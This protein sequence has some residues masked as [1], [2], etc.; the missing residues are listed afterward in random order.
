M[1]IAASMFATL[2]SACGFLSTLDRAH[3]ADAR[4]EALEQI[5]KTTIAICDVVRAEGSTNSLRAQG[6]IDGEVKGLLRRLVEL[7]VSVSGG[8]EQT[9]YQ[10]VRQEDLAGSLKNVLDCR[11]HISDKMI[12]VLLRPAGPQEDVPPR[13]GTVPD[14]SGPRPLYVAPGPAPPRSF[15]S[16]QYTPDPNKRVRAERCCMYGAQDGN[17][18]CNHWTLQPNSNQRVD[19]SELSATCY[20]FGKPGTVVQYCQ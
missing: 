3:A 7:G 19:Y 8:A 13:R 6:Q 16:P 4:Q 5:T 1:H 10:G 18:W 11:Q 15:V 14:Q 20:C 9:T 2:L 17:D 12:E